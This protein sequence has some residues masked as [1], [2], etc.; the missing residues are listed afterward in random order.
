MNTPRRL[1]KDEIEYVID[2]VVPKKG[3]PLKTAESIC[4]INR[5]KLISQLQKIE[6]CPCAIDEFKEEIKK[7]WFKCQIT[8]G[9]SVGIT[10]A[11]SI[12]ERQTQQT[13]NSV[14]FEE[15]ILLS[16]ENGGYVEEIGKFIDERINNNK[17]VQYFENDQQYLDISKEGW[18][19]PS[20]N[21]YGKMSWEKVLAITRHPGKIIEVCTRTGRKV[22]ASLGKSFLVM[23]NKKLV[24]INGSDLKI[25]DKL[26]LT[27]KFPD[28]DF[29]TRS[30]L[31]NNNETEE[32]YAS[33]CM[34]YGIF[35]KIVCDENGKYNAVICTPEKENIFNDVYMDDVISITQ[36]EMTYPYLYD[37]TVENTKNFMLLSGLNMA[38][39]F[40]S[41]GISNK[42]VLAGVPRFSELLGAAKESKAP[43]CSLYFKN[44]YTS[45][46][47]IRK[48]IKDSIKENFLKD[49]LLEE[50][51]HTSEIKEKKWYKTYSSL[52]GTK[53]HG[54]D[55]VIYLKL[56]RFTLFENQIT[57]EKIAK[58]IEDAY[59][60]VCVIYSPNF[61]CEIDIF[62]NT[63]EIR[64]EDDI[65]NDDEECKHVYI[66]EIVISTIKK[67]N[68]SGIA[69]VKN[70][71][72]E[73]RQNEWTIDT[74]GGDLLQLLAHPLVDS[75][76]TISN[77][78]WEIYKIFGIEAARQ[79]LVEEFG[80][81][82]SSDGTFV[83]DCHIKLLV[84]IMTFSGTITSIS[85][86]GM[87]KETCG[88]M[89]KASFEES[90]DNFLKA[91]VY[92]EK[93]TTNG[94]SA[95]IML[96]KVA[97]FG[98]GICDILYDLPKTVNDIVIEKN[99]Q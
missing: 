84:D 81:V 17:D 28:F 5:K 3:L 46:Q 35:T 34:M 87:K 12:G 24:Q 20:V 26:P 80:A 91:G 50:P 71:F 23:Q 61:D 94:V 43:I 49:F 62:V 15:K 69:N 54:Y 42:T 38:D 60:D 39:T 79:Y 65:F 59:S 83:N 6:I 13:L 27:I 32:F 19:I 18:K 77:N 89:A 21:E 58:K 88:P 22:T 7:N 52:F 53:W 92:G 63:S 25:G 45:I 56:N 10:T 86:Y 31:K 8:P 36:K 57:L 30:L 14:S 4:E 99:S 98:T 75:T 9:E 29:D 82:M 44:K 95:S 93:E 64:N 74:E 48:S 11:Q 78:I 47:E 96:G 33:I 70:I 85:R 16:N 40:H 72:Y 37:F 90:L 97:K 76:R 51:V 68:L 67:I 73:K 55:K 2:F 41:T 1:S 66:E